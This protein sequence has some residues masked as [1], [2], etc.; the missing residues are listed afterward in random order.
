MIG[1]IEAAVYGSFMVLSFKE[2]GFEPMQIPVPSSAIDLFLSLS[3]VASVAR[4]IGWFF[5]A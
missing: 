5:L 2:A 4:L 1:N 3:P